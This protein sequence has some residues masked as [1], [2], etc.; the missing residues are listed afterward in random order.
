VNILNIV[1]KAIQIQR[2]ITDVYENVLVSSTVFFRV[3]TIRWRQ[4]Q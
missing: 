4:Y 3:Q 1:V 2:S